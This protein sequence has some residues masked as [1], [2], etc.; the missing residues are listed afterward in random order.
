[1]YTYTHFYVRI[2]TLIH[3]YTGSVAA[4]ELYLD[5]QMCLWMSRYIHLIRFCDLN[6]PRDGGLLATWRGYQEDGTLE[7]LGPC[8][9]SLLFRAPVTPTNG[10]WH[11]CLIWN[12]YVI[13]KPDNK[14]RTHTSLRPEEARKEQTVKNMGPYSRLTYLSIYPS[15]YLYRHARYNM[16]MYICP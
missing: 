1:M 12:P 6:P 8:W 16:Y 9:G 14:P 5:L 15:I 7:Y 13:Q 2:C 11:G 4:K 10:S 3:R